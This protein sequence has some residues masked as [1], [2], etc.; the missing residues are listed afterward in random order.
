[1]RS[2][3]IT[4]LLHDAEKDGKMLKEKKGNTY[5]LHLPK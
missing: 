3:I 2:E 1:M 4:K 5:I